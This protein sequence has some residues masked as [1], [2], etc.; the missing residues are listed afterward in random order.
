MQGLYA[1]SGD[2]DREYLDRDGFPMEAKRIME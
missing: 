1:G 2:G